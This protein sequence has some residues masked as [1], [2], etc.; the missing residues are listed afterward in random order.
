MAKDKPLPVTVINREDGTVNEEE[1]AR[2]NRANKNTGPTG[3]PAR[4]GGTPKTPSNYYLPTKPKEKKIKSS[5]ILFTYPPKK[6]IY[7]E[8]GTTEVVPMDGQK[9]SWSPEE[10]EK[11]KKMF[12]KKKGKER[13]ISKKEKAAGK[14]KKVEKRK[15]KKQTAKKSA[16]GG[17]YGMMGGG[18]VKK[19]GYM[20]GGKVY[21]QPRK[22]TYKAG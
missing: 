12:K 10:I 16:V 4:R 21:G 13:S 2:I 22:A 19:Y 11:F 7:Y 3:R 1:T 14:K 8:D 20:G 6:R 18:K 5:V 9:A 17:T 15:S